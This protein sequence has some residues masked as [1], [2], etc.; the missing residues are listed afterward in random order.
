MSVFNFLENFNYSEKMISIIRA[1]LSL[2]GEIRDIINNNY[3]MYKE[4]LLIPE[5]HLEHFVNEKWVEQNFPIRE[6]Y[7]VR[8]NGEYVGMASYQNLGDFAYIGYVYVKFG[9]HRKGY[10]R[11]IMQFLE[12]RAKSDQLKEIRLFVNKSADW[13]EKAYESMGFKLLSSDKQEILSMNQGIFAKYYEEGQTLL[14]KT[15]PPLKPTN[16]IHN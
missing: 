6:F 11:N 14:F 9:N 15:L 13:A 8:E 7:L 12:M 2:M 5:D 3:Q 16:I 4:I 10:G 1:S